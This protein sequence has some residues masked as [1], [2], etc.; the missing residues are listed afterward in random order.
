MPLLSKIEVH[1]RF[2]NKNLELLS[3]YK[4]SCKSV[5]IKCYCGN[6]FYARP[7]DVF[8]NNTRSCGCYSKIKIAKRFRRDITNEKFGKL[9][10]IKPIKSD[11]NH[12]IIWL[13]RCD[14]GVEKKMPLSY[15][16]SKKGI[17]SCGCS[18]NKPSVRWSG[19]GE[20]SG[21][22]WSYVKRNSKTRSRNIDFNITIQDAWGLFLKQ[23]R[24]CALT[25]VKINFIR[26]YAHKKN[27]EE[28]TASL[29]RINNFK[30]YTMDNI[31]WVH[32]IVNKMKMNLDEKDFLMWCN[33]I[34]EKMNL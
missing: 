12:R 1:S 23:N 25:G 3:E 13:F 21:T 19:Y 34:C 26:Q 32:K 7:R 22:Y 33:L 17:R 20:I 2:K 9:T 6:T 15:V 14:C 27:G 28:Q 29:D 16:S 24:R 10:A 4:K 8:S 11:K 30:G 18:K 5:K 31:Q